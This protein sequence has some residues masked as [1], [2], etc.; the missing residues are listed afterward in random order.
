MRLHRPDMGRVVADGEDA[1]VNGRVQRLDA[2]V[3]HLGKTGEVGD[4]EDSMP[5]PTHRLRRA[6]GR[7]EFDAVTDERG[8]EVGKARLVA[9]GQERAADGNEIGHGESLIWDGKDADPL[10]V[11]RPFR[12][13]PS[14]LR[15]QS[16]R[17]A[18]SRRT[19]LRQAQHERVR[20]DELTYELQSLM[21][22]SYA[23]F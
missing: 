21:R 2:A 8:G 3:H 20:S 19:V 16:K 15:R 5:R 7:D 13:G 18:L 10:S 4:V 12:K 9:D 23:V 14:P 6:A 17:A 22:I 1:A 11:H